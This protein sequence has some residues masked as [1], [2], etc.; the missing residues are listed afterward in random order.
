VRIGLGDD[1]VLVT[2]SYSY[3]PPNAAAFTALNERVT[4]QILEGMAKEGVQLAQASNN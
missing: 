1:A 2:I 3:H 4:W